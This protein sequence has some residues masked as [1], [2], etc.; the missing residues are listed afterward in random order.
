MIIFNARFDIR[1]SNCLA[2]SLPFHVEFKLHLDIFISIPVIK[3]MP[4]SL[5]SGPS[6]TYV[7]FY[8]HFNTSL[9]TCRVNLV[10]ALL[11]IGSLPQHRKS[12]GASDSTPNAKYGKHICYLVR[13]PVHV[14]RSQNQIT[15]LTHL[16][17]EMRISFH[18][19]IQD[20]SAITV[21]NNYI[22]NERK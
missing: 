5:T 21:F 19:S 3:Q 22:V 1:F 2:H 10:F 14:E 6:C 18:R 7:T 20:S 9:I 12:R 15:A 17:V 13:N 8:I 11:V 4:G 16:N